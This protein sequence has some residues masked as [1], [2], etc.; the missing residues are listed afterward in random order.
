MNP[1]IDLTDFPALSQNLVDDWMMWMIWGSGLLEDVGYL[2]FPRGFLRLA[3]D[4]LLGDPA[5]AG[6]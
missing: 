2:G 4:R 6:G 5:P 1:N 3:V